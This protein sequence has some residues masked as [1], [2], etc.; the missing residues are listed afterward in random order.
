MKWTSA[1]YDLPSKDAED[2]ETTY[3]LYAQPSTWER[4]KP[5]L[6]T[7]ILA[8]SLLFNIF[9]ALKI[10]TSP[11]T[12]ESQSQETPTKYAG[13]TF[14]TPQ[15][16][17]HTTPYNT[18]NHTLSTQ[19]WSTLNYDAGSIALSNTYVKT[20]GLPLGQPFPWDETKTLYFLGAHHS[21]HCLKILQSSFQ[22]LL[23]PISV[24]D[25][26]KD[27]LT[28]PLGHL[29][30]C[31]DSLLSD[32]ICYADD[33]PW[34]TSRLHPGE[35]GE[36]QTRMCRDFSKLEEWA[37]NHTSCWR[38][39]APTDDIDTLLRYRYCPKG[40]PYGDRIREVF[41]DEDEWDEV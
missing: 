34:Y 11:N 23:Y 26:P 14:N 10:L 33:T 16:H 40:T 6:F 32:T 41:G 38:H 28:W 18:P 21:I 25:D 36:G 1:Y 3:Q 12:Q 4:L 24:K 5:R 8:T 13:L 19:S 22:E 2:S 29:T 20:M 35:P 37:R 15:T 31:L 9:T 39:I 7:T 30:H 27:L 17:T